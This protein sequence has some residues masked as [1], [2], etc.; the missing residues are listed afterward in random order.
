MAGPSNGHELRSRTRD[1]RGTHG[2]VPARRLRGDPPGSSARGEPGPD[3]DGSRA[4]RARGAARPGGTAARHSAV[5]RRDGRSPRPGPTATA[6]SAS[7]GCRPPIQR[8][9]AA[10][11]RW[12]SSSRSRAGRSPRASVRPGTSAGGCRTCRSCPTATAGTC[13]GRPGGRAP[14][15]SPS[16]AAATATSSRRSAGRRPSTVHCPHRRRGSRCSPTT[17]RSTATG[18]RLELDQPGRH[19]EA[20]LREDHG[21]RRGPGVPSPSTRSA[22]ALRCLARGHR[23]TGTAPT[24]RAWHAAALGDGPFTYRV[25]L[26]LDGARY[27]ATAAWPADEIAGNE[28]SVALRVHAGASG[29]FPPLSLSR[30]AS[31]RSS[32]SA[33]SLPWRS[34]CCLLACVRLPTSVGDD[35]ARQ[36]RDQTQPGEH[37]H[38]G[39]E[40]AARRFGHDVA[41]ADGGHRDDRP[42]VARARG[43]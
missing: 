17:R 34:S 10:R 11:R 13:S 26:V 31:M 7:T 41:V 18:W 36:R 29:A 6:I 30:R 20:S 2:R 38:R 35:H 3:H 21:S 15:T 40:A 32:A 4:A 33:C 43:S 23:R 28:P 12:R 14:T 5:P 1:N 16:S 39:H 22:P 24:S 37:Q 9:S 27:V 8:T 19:A 42:P 25:E